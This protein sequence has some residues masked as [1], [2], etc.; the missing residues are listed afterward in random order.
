M[1]LYADMPVKAW[2]R[3]GLVSRMSVL[4]QKPTDDSHVPIYFYIESSMRACSVFPRAF[5]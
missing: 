4:Q 1:A 2:L 5:G 3:Y